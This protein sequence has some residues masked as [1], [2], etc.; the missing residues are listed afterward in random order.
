MKPEELKF[1]ETHE[2]VHVAGDVATVG[3]SAV[4]VEALTDLVYM[5]LPEPGTSVTAGESFGEVES[6]KAT[7]DLYSPVDGEIMAVNTELPD[8][9]D[10]L[11]EDPY[12]K[13]WI[14]KVKLSNRI[15][16]PS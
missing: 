9:L 1:A 6:V 8:Q 3:I 5:E 13:G 7:S 10:T 16:L 4:A 14:L 15:R 11:S 2:W 12:G